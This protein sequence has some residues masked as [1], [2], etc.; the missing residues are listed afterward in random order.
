[1]ALLTAAGTLARHGVLVRNLQGIE[2]L[3]GIDT[4]VFDKTGTLTRDGMQVSRM[5]L[6]DDSLMPAYKGLA[7]AIAAQSRHPVSRAVAGFSQAWAVRWEVLACEEISGQGLKAQVR[8]VGR[9]PLTRSGQCAWVLPDSHPHRPC[10]AMSK[11][12]IWP[13]A[14]K[15]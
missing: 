6:L 12:C 5:E 13:G 9:G 8:A 11:P 15:W 4:L 1:M 14:S 10:K 2:S 7:A 3:A